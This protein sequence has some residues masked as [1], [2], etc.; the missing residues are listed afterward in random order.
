MKTR[1]I[2][3]RCTEET[4]RRWRVFVASRGFENYEKALNYLLDQV[5]RRWEPEA[6]VFSP[7]NE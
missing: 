7:K 4:W 6:E 3:I 1:K 2:I 5:E